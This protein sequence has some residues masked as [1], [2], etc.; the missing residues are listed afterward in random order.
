MDSLALIISELQMVTDMFLD[1]N[2][3][4]QIT[5]VAFAGAWIESLYIA[6]KVFENGKDQALNNKL[7]E[8]MNILGSIINALKSEEKK[9]P[10]ITGLIADL[11]SVKNIYDGLPSIKNSPGIPEDARKKTML[12]NE[13][14]ATLTKKIEELRTKFING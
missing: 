13:E 7:S 12:T 3:Q 14:V 6:S 10:A 2:N 8:Q 1:E 11:N 5:P 4:Q 9:E